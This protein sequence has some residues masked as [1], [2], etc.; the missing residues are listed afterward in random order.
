MTESLV[1]APVSDETLAATRKWK[2][3][4]PGKEHRHLAQ[5]LLAG[6]GKGKDPDVIAALFSE[7]VVFE[8]PGDD[9]V[10]PWIGRNTGRGGVTDSTSRDRR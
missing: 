4:E 8:I 9:G 2:H 3:H 1:R 6:I 10:L 5:E 7:N